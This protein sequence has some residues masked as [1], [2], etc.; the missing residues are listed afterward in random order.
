M[1]KGLA[2]LYRLRCKGYRPWSNDQNTM[3]KA[4][5]LLTKLI[6]LGDAESMYHLGKLYELNQNSSKAIEL[7]TSGAEKDCYKCMHALG[8][9]YIKIQGKQKQ[10][11]ML[12]LN[13][14]CNVDNPHAMLTVGKMY[15]TGFPSKVSKKYHVIRKDINQAISIFKQVL[16]VKDVNYNYI[17]NSPKA[18]AG[19]LLGVLYKKK[20]DVYRSMYYYGISGRRTN[21]Y[22]ILKDNPA[23]R[24]EIIQTV[25]R[26]KGLDKIDADDLS[27]EIKIIKNIVEN[28]MHEDSYLGDDPSNTLRDRKSVV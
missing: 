5:L 4:I 21:V 24:K 14:V 23:L 9:I 3:D 25:Y 16:E 13:V 15:M 6:S 19:S 10:G 20:K 28:V 11:A 26:Y 27:S 22:E 1:A 8:D 18:E 7:F 17:H 12:L 2:D